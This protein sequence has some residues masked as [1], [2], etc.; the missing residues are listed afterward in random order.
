MA[1]APDNLLGAY[2]RDRR[3]K[4]DPAALGLPATR[5]RTPG[6]RREEVAQRAH[7][8]VAWYTWLEQGRGGAP[9]A[10]VLDRLARALMLNEA[11][12]E[13][14]FLIGL[15]HPP[16]VRYHAPAGVTPRLQ[17]VLDSLDASPAIIR[18]ATWDV[19]AWNDAAAATL[20]DYATLPPV[21]RNILRLIFVDAGVRH[22]QSDWER[23]ARFAVGGFRAD[24]ARSGATQA[25]QAFVDEMRATSAEFDAMWRD[26]DIRTHEEAT[27]EIRHP[28]AGRIALEHSTFSVTGRP[29]LSLVIFT[30]ATPAD[31]ARIRELVAA[32]E[33]ARA[34]Q[35]P[36]A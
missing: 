4:L 25:V 24:V 12:R 34:T 7:V 20:T 3:E 8:S 28:R 2:L 6:L 9:S 32:R 30:P 10:D 27:K 14:L 1:D 36:A 26:H 17:H 16:E 15:G 29:D 18:T 19:A 35:A 5:R 31:R 23:V 22:A 13:H 33:R 21:A 11:E